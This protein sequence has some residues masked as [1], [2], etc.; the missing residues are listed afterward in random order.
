MIYHVTY[1]DAD[2]A[3][4]LE[5]TFN[6]AGPREALQNMLTVPSLECPPGTTSISVEVEEVDG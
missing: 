1:S 2:G 5:A 6:A 4:L 3:V